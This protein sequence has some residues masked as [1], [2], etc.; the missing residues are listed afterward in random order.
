MEQI[1]R[2]K[3]ILH[4]YIPESAVPAIAEW[5]YAFDFKLKIKRARATKYGD[6]R[7]PVG[8]LNH[9]ITINHDLNKYAFL[10]T[11]VHEIAHLSAFKKYGNNIQSHGKEWK[12]EYRILLQPFLHEGVFPAD[13]IAALK[14]YLQNPAATVCTD[15]K[16]FKTLRRYDENNDGRVFLDELPVQTEFIA[17]DNHTYLK[18][19]KI[20]TRYLC[21]R[22][23]TRHEYLFHGTAQV[24]PVLKENPV[25]RGFNNIPALPLRQAY[26][27]N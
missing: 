7:P 22:V 21:S 12:Q 19:K 14:A 9:Q 5:I 16:L 26:T 25:K 6:Y 13:V 4:K 20:R 18:L 24:K 17:E 1:E 15:K 2:N 3:S 23:N 10:N 8:E 11:L 27:E